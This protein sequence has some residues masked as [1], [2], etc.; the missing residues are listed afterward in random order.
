MTRGTVQIVIPIIHL[1][2]TLL[3]ASVLNKPARVAA[4]EGNNDFEST[5]KANKVDNQ[6]KAAATLNNRGHDL[7]GIPFEIVVNS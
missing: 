3:F 7:D 6:V 5:Y 2:L 4:I 1:M